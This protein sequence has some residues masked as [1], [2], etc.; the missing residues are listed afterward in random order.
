VYSLPD[1]LAL[2]AP[3]SG[4]GK[5]LAVVLACSLPFVLA[6]FVFFVF[7]PT[8]QASYGE[9]IHPA[10]AVAATQVRQVVL[11]AQ[12]HI[13]EQAFALENIKGQ[14]LIVSVGTGACDDAC[15][16]R[17]FV[18]RQLRE[19]IGKDRD[20][21][22]RVWLII[23]DAPLSPDT[24][25]LLKD[26]TVLRVSPEVVAQWLGQADVSQERQEFFIVDP[27][28]NAMLHMPVPADGKQAH[29]ALHVLQKLLAASA[30]WDLPGR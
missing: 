28:G 3:A 9:L 22:D 18:Q 12:G 26:V 5:L 2:R 24:V 21:V 7:K 25:A 6:Y 14:W 23:D 27:M 19:M 13:S 10:R 15:M 30:V 1:P 11:D 8:G 16:Q 17:L 20:R 29:A 4:R